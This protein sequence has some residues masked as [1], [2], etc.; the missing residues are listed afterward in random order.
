MS[1]DPT[2]PLFD[3]AYQSILNFDIFA[4]A[5]EKYNLDHDSYSQIYTKNNASAAFY[6]DLITKMIPDLVQSIIE[7][8]PAKEEIDNLKAK[9][10]K[11]LT[12]NNY[13]VKPQAKLAKKIRSKVP[14]RF[15][16]HFNS[17]VQYNPM[18]NWVMLVPQEVLD[19]NVAQFTMRVPLAIGATISTFVMEQYNKTCPLVIFAFIKTI[20]NLYQMG[21]DGINIAK[22]SF[23][24]LTIQLTNVVTYIAQVGS[25]SGAVDALINVA[26]M[27]RQ[28]V[29]F[30]IA[31]VTKTGDL[32]KIVTNPALQ[33]AI[34]NLTAAVA[35][36][37]SVVKTIVGIVGP[38]GL[39][40]DVEHY[41]DALF[42]KYTPS[43]K[44]VPVKIPF[45][46]SSIVITVE[47]TML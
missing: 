34:G 25:L 39:K 2:K 22:K 29:A 1:I 11:V 18:L 14:E 17:A 36:P 3:S 32:T 23:D 42:G 13:L 43:D 45:L 8:N 40:D 44:L 28:S 15:V 30:T 47:A 5:K 24:L 7:L 21:M 27:L 16:K 4:Y 9:I 20:D 10:M 31:L 37:V 35:N 46:G 33:L 6:S 26:N 41:L 38:E 12:D 19:P